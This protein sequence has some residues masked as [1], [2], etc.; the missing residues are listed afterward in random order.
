MENPYV[1]LR[2]LSG[3]SQKDFAAKYKLSKTTMVYIES[4]QYPD[5]SE[6]MILSLG[7]ECFEKGVPAKQILA[8][9]YNANDLANAYHIWQ[10]KERVAAKSI[11]LIEPPERWTAELSPMHFYIKA[12]TGSLQKFCK[13]LK[14]PAASVLRFTSGAT[15]Q[16]PKAVEDAL[17]QVGFEGLGKLLVMQVA[18]ADEHAL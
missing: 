18:W 4:G 8:S 11:F 14:V 16:M 13:T 17:R 12:T 15:R 10:R 1:R 5:L 2:T 3:I 9:E 7:Q 6:K